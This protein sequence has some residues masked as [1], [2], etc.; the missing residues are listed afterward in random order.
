MNDSGSSA[1]QMQQLTITTYTQ[2]FPPAID[3]HLHVSS[4]FTIPVQPK[5]HLYQQMFITMF[6]TITG[7]SGIPVITAG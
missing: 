4:F 1:E 2:E 3:F 5:K 6:P 7:F